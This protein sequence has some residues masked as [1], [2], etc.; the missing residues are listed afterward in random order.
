MSFTAPIVLF[1]LIVLPVVWYLL[2]ATPPAPQ[3]QIFPAASLLAGLTSS[4]Q[5]PAR[6]PLWLLALRLLAAALIIVGLAGPVRDTSAALPGSGPV[7]LVLDDGAAAAADWPERMR[8]A[9][10]LAARASHAG[11]GMALLTTAQAEDGG[12]PAIATALPAAAFAGGLAALQ[13]KP[14]PEN[15]DAAA[16]AL[17]AWRQPGAAVFYIGDGVADGGDDAG[18]MAALAGAGTV[19]AYCCGERAGLRL[20]PPRNGAERMTARIAAVPASA[21]RRLAVLAQAGD[22]RTLAR[23]ETVLQAGSSEAEAAIALPLEVRN[24]LDRLI[25]DGPPSAEAVFLLDQS[26]QLRPVGLVANPGQ[27]DTPLT[28]TFYYLKRALAPGSEI[29]TGS[30]RD[31]LKRDIS[32]IVLADTPLAPGPEAEALANWV[33]RG[34]ILLRFAGPRMAASG[35]QSAPGLDGALAV[36]PDPLLPVSLIAGD[37]ALGGALSWGEPAHL[38]AFPAASPFADLKPPAEVTVSRQVL[39]QPS[40]GLSRQSWA[41]LEDGTPL[42]TA[43]PAGDGQIVLFHV[44][45]NAAWSDL[46]LS[47][48]FVQMLQRVVALSS[49]VS[50]SGAD[51]VLAPESVL[52][53]FGTMAPPGGE[54]TGLSARSIATATPSPAHPPGWYGPE[55]NRRALN[56]GASGNPPEALPPVPGA[57][58]APLGETQT[59]D[60][61]GAWLLAAAAL[62]LIA[63]LLATLSLR[64]LLLACVLLALC[65]APASAAS[66][67]AAALIPKLAAIST[68]D[69]AVDRTS[70]TGLRALSAAVTARTAA[71]LGT[72]DSVVPGE[73][74]LS[75]YPLLYWPVAQFEP[76]LSADAVQALN[77]YMANGGIL[78]IDTQGG[79]IADPG[80]GAGFAPDAGAALRRLTAGMVIPPLAPLSADHVLGHTFYLLTEFP[81]RFTGAPVWVQRGEDRGN[82]SVSA[83]IIGANAWAAA[84]AGEAVPLPGGARQGQIALR[85]GVNLVMYA[86]TGNYKGDQVH[87]PA[88]MQRLGR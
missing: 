22:G 84:W 46:P 47:G 16:A 66:P 55:T 12:L 60:A 68:G 13:P 52:D 64:G 40:P 57:S 15:R 26:W 31:L 36:N 17:R 10:A 27:D 59:V 5:T 88:I 67:E 69:E 24:R 85:F 87:V 73:D 18:F 63:D 19:R 42:V 79:D 4:E 20:A 53:G 30:I 41:T 50:A 75:V 80:S 70:M 32:V 11:R 21:P 3:M 56:L 23:A 81:G 54:A 25:L 51:A 48:L 37:R 8:L 74:D 29:R 86:L 71:T 7:L 83:V 34:G 78:L 35:N 77:A 82:D 72:P 45:A 38:A 2:R 14:W 43:A 1:G 58:A 9:A 62:L 28:G 44:T 65:A 6:S 33:K 39:A 61:Y 49:G 76:S